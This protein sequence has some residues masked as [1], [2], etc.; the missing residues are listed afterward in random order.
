M[1]LV[2]FSQQSADSF[3]SFR[4]RLS[5]EHAGKIMAYIASL[6]ADDR[7]MLKPLNKKV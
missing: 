6:P 2:K 5:M 4:C 1:V 3:L 7:V